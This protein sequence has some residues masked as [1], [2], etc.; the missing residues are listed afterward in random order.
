MSKLKGKIALVT[1]ASRG[2]GRGIAMRLAQ[3]GAIVAVHYGKNYD[4][5][6]EVVARFSIKAAPPLHSVLT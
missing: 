4:A 2:I 5:A 3:D 6:E 1:G